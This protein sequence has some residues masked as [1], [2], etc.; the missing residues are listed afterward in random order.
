MQR[1]RIEYGGGWDASVL[2]QE[3][4][5]PPL[6]VP[7]VLSP[8]LTVDGRRLYAYRR[9]GDLLFP[10]WQFTALGDTVIP[11]L[12]AVLDAL[13]ADAHPGAVAGFFLTVQP[14][15][16]LNGR[17]VSAKQWL[18]DGGPPEPVIEMPRDLAA[19]Y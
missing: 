9:D 7:A 2:E 1:A 15:L 13:P 16:V 14:D 3:L 18:E 19:G 5:M 4:G 17:A 10:E 12:H 6:A 11:Y 8:V